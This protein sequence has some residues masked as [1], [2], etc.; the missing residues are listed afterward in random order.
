MRIGF[1]QLRP[2]F[3]AVKEN[4]RKAVALLDKV[5]DATIVLPELFN[6][7]Y[8]FRNDEELAALAEPVPG[9]YTTAEMQKIAK[10]RKLNLVFG[11]AQRYKGKFYNSA[12]CVSC[13]GK[14]EV[15]QKVHLFDR[16]K[17]FFTR[18]KSF[19]IVSA[20]EARLGIL[21]CFDWIF[22]EVSRTL[23]LQGAQVLCHPSNLVLP[24]AQYAMRTRCVE[25]R[26]F[27]VTANRIGTERRG[28]VSL[29]FTG[30]SQIVGPTGDVLA[31]AGDRSE[32]LRV[33]EVDLREANNKNITVNNNIFQDRIPSLYG[34][35]TR[36]RRA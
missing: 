22:P 7:S 8:L 13:K 26:V 32:S 17:L 19:K 5:S 18:G 20:G 23:C 35:L 2:K 25:N 14:V 24:Y 3:G 16:E 6:T 11:M 4:V 1:L 10:R 21:L 27:A 28:T 33:V 31:S 34:E 29:T 12:V 30:G 36:K 9:G 15:Y